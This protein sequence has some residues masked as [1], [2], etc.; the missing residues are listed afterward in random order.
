MA[1][2]GSSSVLKFWDSSA[3]DGCC[4]LLGDSLNSIIIPRVPGRPQ[5]LKTNGRKVETQDLKNLKQ[6]F[7]SQIPLQTARPQKP[8]NPQ[9]QP[10][11]EENGEF[12]CHPILQELGH[13]LWVAPT[14]PAKLKKKRRICQSSLLLSGAI[15]GSRKHKNSIAVVTGASP[16]AKMHLIC[17]T[18]GDVCLDQI[19]PNLCFLRA[20]KWARQAGPFLGPR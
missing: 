11:P 18:L 4:H 10:E 14:V 9:N 5:N 1:G 19:G 2:L 20:Q 16:V 6:R 7:A 15:S 3:C 12:I 17:C 13:P 8:Q